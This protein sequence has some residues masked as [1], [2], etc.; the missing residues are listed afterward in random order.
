[1]KFKGPFFKEFVI[2]GPVSSVSLITRLSKKGIVPGID[3]GRYGLGLR[4]CLMVA[5]TE[6]RSKEEIDRLAKELATI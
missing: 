4:G 5:V 6:K 1:L 2:E 3:L